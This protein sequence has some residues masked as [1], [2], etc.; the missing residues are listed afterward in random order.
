[1]QDSQYYSI[2]DASRWLRYVANCIAFADDAAQHLSNNVTV[3]LQEGKLII[4][5]IKVKDFYFKDFF[6]LFYFY[7]K[8]F[9][10]DFY[11]DFYFVFS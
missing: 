11:L 5:L 4:L 2:L 9:I 3:V 10:L 1:M 7:F 8:I 6:L